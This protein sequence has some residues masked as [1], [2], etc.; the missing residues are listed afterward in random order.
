MFPKL[1]KKM[2]EEVTVMR[3]FY[4]KAKSIADVT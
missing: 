4:P 1:S 2:S 3:G